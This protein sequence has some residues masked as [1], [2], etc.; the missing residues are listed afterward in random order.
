MGVVNIRVVYL[1]DVY[2][3]G[4]DHFIQTE[5]GFSSLHMFSID[6]PL[7]CLMEKVKDFFF[8]NWLLMSS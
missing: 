6:W 4:Y 1:I 3:I 8:K 5:T 7:Q 2:F